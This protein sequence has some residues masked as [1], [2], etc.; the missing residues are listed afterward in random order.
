M[1]GHLLIRDTV[2]SCQIWV[3]CVI[4]RPLIFTEPAQITLILGSEHCCLKAE[5]FGLI[6][7]VTIKKHKLTR[8]FEN[9]EDEPTTTI[10]YTDL[11]K[12]R[13][14]HCMFLLKHMKTYL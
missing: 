5:F 6:I 2:K 1:F 14:W 9:N 4:R 13:S 7:N 12:C 10:L 11:V 8:G 3:N